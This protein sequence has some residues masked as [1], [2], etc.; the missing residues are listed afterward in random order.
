MRAEVS[1]LEGE[2]QLSK[3]QMQEIEQSLLQ[4]EN[5]AAT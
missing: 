1:Q 3:D 4:R 2:I 5:S